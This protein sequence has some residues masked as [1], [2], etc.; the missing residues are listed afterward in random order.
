MYKTKWIYWVFQFSGWGL[1][2]G[3]LGLIQYLEDELD[4]QTVY[5]LL[6]HLI[7][8]IIITHALRFVLLRFNLVNMKVIKLL[9][10]AILVN[11]LAALI[12]SFLVRL[13]A[14]FFTNTEVFEEDF[15][16]GY[17]INA[18]VYTLFLLMWSSVYLTYHLFQKNRKQE[19]Q[20]LELR[21]A[22]VESELKTLRAQLNPHFL[23]NSL[24]SIRALIEIAPKDAKNAVGQLSN[25]LRGSLILGKNDLVDVN[26]ELKLV[27]DY[28]KLE[29]TRFEERLDYNI[30][31]SCKSN[32]YIPPFCIQTLVENGIKHG[33]SKL[34]EGGAIHIRI[35]GNKDILKVEVENTGVLNK[36]KSET[37]IGL[38]NIKR[39]L[40][41]HFG[42]N[43]KFD[44][45]EKDN[46]VVV[47]I[48][49]KG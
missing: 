18:L 4:R 3:L 49:I 33:I 20:N 27:E 10:R 35:S 17:F 43:A 23:F 22:Q 13:F 15:F 41:L 36:S 8:L 14:Y 19:L 39:R 29:K 45:K 16:L 24:N 1:F 32:W 6:F 40:D 31:N 37:Q 28:L 46:S 21:N 7:T 30:V 47:V 38:T 26:D 48:E 5:Q 11:F 42:E 2:I 12:I 34:K 25:V 9:P 44:I